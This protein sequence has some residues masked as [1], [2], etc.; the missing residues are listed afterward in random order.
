MQPE[1]GNNY[2]ISHNI[3]HVIFAVYGG[4]VIKYC[5]LLETYALPTDKLL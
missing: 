2:S 3:S 5:R 4:D 1:N